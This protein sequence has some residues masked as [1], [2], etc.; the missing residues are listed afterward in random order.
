[1]RYPAE[2]GETRCKSWRVL[3]LEDTLWQAGI[4]AQQKPLVIL[5]FS[6][7]LL[8]RPSVGDFLQVY[9]SATWPRLARRREVGDVAGGLGSKQPTNGP[10]VPVKPP[11]R[12]WRLLSTMAG[13]LPCTMD[14]RES[15]SL[16]GAVKMYSLKAALEEM[17]K[18][19]NM[20]G[21]CCGGCQKQIQTY[22]SLTAYLE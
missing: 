6:H 8:S 9:F 1:M 16:A 13:S 14:Q 12:I 2:T 20:A 7:D 22:C 5:H 4:L 15:H 18:E 11:G 19:M 3:E 10:L 21:R 17:M